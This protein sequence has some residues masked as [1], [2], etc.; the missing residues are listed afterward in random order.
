MLSLSQP[1]ILSC[2]RRIILQLVLTH[3]IISHVVRGAYFRIGNFPFSQ[4]WIVL[5]ILIGLKWVFICSTCDDAIFRP[6]SFWRDMLYPDSWSHTCESHRVRI[7]WDYSNLIMD[8][9]RHERPSLRISH[10]RIRFWGSWS[11]KYHTGSNSYRNRSSYSK[12]SWIGMILITIL[13]RYIG[14]CEY[15]SGLH[16]W[17][18]KCKRWRYHILPFSIWESLGDS[19]DVW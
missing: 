9:H 19:I 6:T 13:T 7:F 2:V 11:C 12:L 3:Q 5:W 15:R 10:W 18:G 17:L 14:C 4:E 8:S 1:S 16:T